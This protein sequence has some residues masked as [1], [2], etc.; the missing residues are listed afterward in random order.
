MLLT[1]KDRLIHDH[2]IVVPPWIRL[3]PVGITGL[4]IH[5][6]QRQIR[7]L[8]DGIQHDQKI[9]RRDGNVCIHDRIQLFRNLAGYLHKLLCI[10]FHKQRI[11]FRLLS[12]KAAVF[13]LITPCDPVD[14][15]LKE[16]PEVRPVIQLSIRQNRHPDA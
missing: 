15:P 12:V 2:I 10:P 4:V 13:Y 14:M 5:F 16:I 1:R 6:Q 7:M 3:G 9:R 8:L 11:D